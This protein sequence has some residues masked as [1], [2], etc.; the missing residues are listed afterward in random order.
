VSGATGATGTALIADIIWRPGGVSGG[1]VAATWP[2]V[3]ALV[4]AVQ[5]TARIYVD[6]NIAAAVVPPGLWNGYGSASLTTYDAASFLVTISDGATLEDYSEIRN[7]TVQCECFTT[8]AFTFS[9]F[10]QF[11]IREFGAIAIEAGSTVSPIQNAQILTVIFD[12]GTL[13]NT[14]KPSLGVLETTAVGQ[15]RIYAHNA[16]QNE[17]VLLTGSEISGPVGAKVFW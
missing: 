4:D 1:N 7:I 10:A 14:A 13:D 12:Q 8:K 9:Q 17:P 11:F 2:Q 15:S 16:A 6:T 5:G 3:Q